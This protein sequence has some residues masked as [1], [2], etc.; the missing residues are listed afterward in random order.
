VIIMPKRNL[1]MINLDTSN[2]ELSKNKTNNLPNV[3][4][5]GGS[6][7]A[8]KTTF[9]LNMIKGNSFDSKDGIIVMD[10]AGN[11]DYSRI[12]SEAE[13]RNILIENATSVCTV[14]DGP[15]SAFVQL[16][17]MNDFDNVIIE[18][19]GQ[20]PLSVMK[21][22]LTS[23]GVMNM[24]SIYLV[25]PN[26]FKL[27]QAADEVPHA[28]I[29]GL[30]KNDSDIDISKYNPYAKII[31]LEKEGLYRLE[32]ILS[33]LPEERF[34]I[35]PTYVSKH[36]H[37]GPGEIS[38]ISQKVQNPY[39][40]KDE[41]E[42]IL[43]PLASEYDRVKGHVAIDSLTVYSFDGVEGVYS[44]ELIEDE[45]LGNGIILLANRDGRHFTKDKALENIVDLIEKHDENPTPVLR[46]G[47]SKSDF[48]RYINHA[49]ESKQYDDAM[50][51]GEQFEF[52]NNDSSLIKDIL[53]NYALG[54]LELINSGELSISQ[55]LRQGM[56][57][58]YHSFEY[59]NIANK[60]FEEIS[61]IFKD[62]YS[63]MTKSD[64]NE[65]KLGSDSEETIEYI[66]LIRNKL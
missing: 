26:N 21:N 40:S 60:E 15:E 10:A 58:L 61:R 56:G 62:D 1:P 47:S 59:P 63:N 14:C 2:L 28:D 39:Y 8:G 45:N 5:L 41:L 65:I 7:G 18:L 64:W 46:R 30:T 16:E 27:V 6:L 31:R 52:E 54:K 13:N 51:A 48:I 25:D 50:G 17:K 42:M 9:L 33:D 55:R 53:P 32:D 29:I 22:R 38:K 3:T 37:P 24:N 36:K 43:K 4:L 11:I 19:S 23:K 49:L 12:R 20:L 34:S 57:A 35:T 66:Q 44:G